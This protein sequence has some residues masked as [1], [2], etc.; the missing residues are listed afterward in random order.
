MEEFHA[1][2]A[3]VQVCLNYLQLPR[4]FLFAFASL[5]YPIEPAIC[6]PFTLILDEF[7]SFD[8]ELS[9]QLFALR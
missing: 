1:L 9:E 2:Y 6:Y 3:L 5:H 8:P 4:V 7:R